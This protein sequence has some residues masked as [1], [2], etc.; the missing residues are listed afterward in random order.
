MKT[1]EIQTL[2]RTERIQALTVEDTDSHS[3]HFILSDGKKKSYG[4]GSLVTYKEVPAHDTPPDH[5]KI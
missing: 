5:R 4:R 1:Y 3:V 2:A